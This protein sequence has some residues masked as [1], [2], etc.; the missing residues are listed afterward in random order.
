MATEIDP[1]TGLLRTPD[2]VAK[3]AAIAFTRIFLGVMWL[4]EVAVGRNWMLG[5]FGSDVN[6]GWLGS[7]RGAAVLEGGADAIA[8]GTWSWFAVL[9]GAFI[10]PNAGFLAVVTIVVQLA[11]AAAFI[12]GV[13]VRPAALVALVMDLS[14]F[15]LGNSQ[16]PPFFTAMHLFVLATGAGRFYGLDGFLLTRLYPPLKARDR[17]IRWL[18][19]LPVFDARL[20]GPAL[21]GT[22]LLALYF[23]LAIPGRETTRIQLVSLSLA[24]ILGLVAFALYASNLIP[25]R[26]GVIVAALRMFLGLQFLHALWNPA[27]SGV[28]ALPGGMGRDALAELFATVSAAHWSVV[29]TVVDAVF[30]PVPGLWA[31]LF[32]VAQFAIGVMLLLG[33]RTRIASMA[34]AVY[35]GGLILLGLTRYAPFAL[36]LLIPVMAL[37]GG[38]YLSV[39]RVTQGFRYR[40]RYGLPIPQRLVLPLLVLATANAVAAG[41]TAFVHGIEP[42]AY[43][44]SMP[45][46]TT[47]MVAIFSGLLAG[48]GWLQQRP[49]ASVTPVEGRE[50]LT[51]GS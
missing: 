13:L 15:M 33:F 38:A 18:L 49:R 29:G 34:G 47:A 32:A 46:M 8:D 26:L 5:G 17:G 39:D 25:D 20:R 22:S 2:E 3:A 1:H 9:Y 16:I 51:A 48:V 21:A 23:F 45:S 28:D 11:F 31:F 37:D 19:E 30:L 10:E 41:V 43:V 6:A 35:L 44:T 42:G 36:G 27:G 50:L 14:I 4:F 24:A 40:E 7:E 12:F